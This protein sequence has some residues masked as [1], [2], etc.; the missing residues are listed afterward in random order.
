MTRSFPLKINVFR[1]LRDSP[2]HE[3]TTPTSEEQKDNE[4][5]FF[6][7]QQQNVIAIL[8]HVQRTQ[9]L[10]PISRTK[11]PYQ[12]R[13]AKLQDRI[14]THKVAQNRSLQQHLKYEW[15]NAGDIAASLI[16]RMVVRL[17]HCVSLHDN[18]LIT[19]HMNVSTVQISRYLP[20]Y[21]RDI[22][23]ICSNMPNV[24][25]PLFSLSLPKRQA[26]STIHITITLYK[27]LPYSRDN[28][29]P[30]VYKTHSTQRSPPT[31]KSP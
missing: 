30:A 15:R 2:V 6:P 19:R 31:T 5:R 8:S 22:Y 12:V 28:L 25:H 9:P 11:I 13:P 4:Q 21:T 24:V 16:W 27:T 29:R 10:F 26:V 18:C 17:L 3:V 20:H 14:S 1:T 23:K 7:V